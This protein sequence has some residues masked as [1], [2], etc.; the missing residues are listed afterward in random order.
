MLVCLIT[1]EA[2]LEHLKAVSARFL[3]CQV[4]ISPFVLNTCLG[5]SL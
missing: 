5:G 1:N 3:H 4:I 2:G